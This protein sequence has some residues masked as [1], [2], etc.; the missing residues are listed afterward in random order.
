MGPARA[1]V[2]AQIGEL[3]L[4]GTEMEE[5]IRQRDT[6]IARLKRE[7]EEKA[8]AKEAAQEMPASR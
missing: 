2:A 3:S 6:E 4:S 1:R 8:K 7:L 5:A